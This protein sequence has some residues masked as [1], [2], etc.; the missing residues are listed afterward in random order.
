MDLFDYMREQSKEDEEFVK[1][2]YPPFHDS[3]HQSAEQCEEPVFS[4][5]EN[6]VI[7]ILDGMTSFSPE[8]RVKLIDIFNNI[9]C[10][11]NS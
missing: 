11:W 6:E 3:T 2:L 9:I 7:K 10:Y 4:L 8:F 5:K 1:S